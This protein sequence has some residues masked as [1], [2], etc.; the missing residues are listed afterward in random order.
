MILLLLSLSLQKH[1]KK[2][3]RYLIIKTSFIII[4]FLLTIF[5]LQ[6]YAQNIAETSLQSDCSKI[7]TDLYDYFSYPELIELWKNKD[8]NEYL[9]QKVNFILNN[10]IV[11]NSISCNTKIKLQKSPII[12]EFVRVADWNIER[13][14][15]IDEIKNIF[16]N[17]NSLSLKLKT[18]DKVQIKKVRDEIEGLRHSNIIVLNEVDSGMPRTQ[19][20]KV[21]EELGNALGYNYAY[22][23]E[24]LEVDPVHMG[25]QDYK[26]SEERSLVKEGVMQ[27]LEVDKLKYRGLHGTAIL[28]QFPLK[29]VRILRLPLSYDWYNGE[30]KKISELEDIKRNAAGKFVKVDMLR[31]IRVGSRMALIADIN[32]PGLD[33]PITI[34]AVHLENKTTPNKRKEQMQYDDN[35]VI[36]Y[37]FNVKY[38]IRQVSNL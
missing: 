2:F 24:F 29:N 27:N 8:Q 14:F 19:Y 11:D 13:G 25:V 6:A 31:E 1:G 4:L 21:A 34:V 37:N 26:W 22:A 15:K 33:T 28:S 9:R 32:V 7:N 5:S 16:T 3:M 38:L 20:K 18:K 23:P 30:K 10:P 17:S 12:G 36:L 35:Q